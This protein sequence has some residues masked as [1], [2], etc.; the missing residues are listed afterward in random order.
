MSEGLD[1]YEKR[2][3]RGRTVRFAAL[4]ALV[5][6]VLFIDTVVG[7]YEIG[8]GDILRSIFGRMDQSSTEYLVIMT[9]RLP[10]AAAAMLGGAAL[11]VSGLLLQTFFGNPI[12]E[13]Y[14]LG[15]SS[16]A[17][18]F[19]GLVVLAGTRLGLPAATPW[20]MF[21]GAFCGSMMVM[22][23]MLFAASKAKS[24][25]TLLI[26]G[27][28]CGSVCSS[29]ITILTSYA[30]KENIAAFVAWG[31]GSFA[32]ILFD[33]V[34]VL[35]VLTVPMYFVA[36][37]MAKGLNALQLGDNYARSMGVG[38]RLLRMSIVVV[39]SIL[40]A[41]VTAFAGPVSFIGLVVPHFCRL[42]FR[43]HDVRVLLPACILGG[44]AMTGLCDLLARIIV[45]PRELPLSA[46]T[47][48][49]GAPVVVYL[50]RRR[51]RDV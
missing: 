26:I 42:F 51:E 1:I 20:V 32:G 37:S 41:A 7:T 13:S 25:V 2:I 3:R 38:V 43:T 14:V 34:G 18:L 50:L 45:A 46:I 4:F 36:A 35:A 33:R 15:I 6:A 10:R 48:F 40:T 9:I 24:I 23:I 8:F 49:I 47:A 31:M 30:A 11:A 19:V 29:I 28:M 22:L 21:A 16:G 27:M 39:S 44:A 12:V 5:L 17:S